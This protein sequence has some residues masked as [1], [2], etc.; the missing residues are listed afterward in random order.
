MTIINRIVTYAIMISSI[1]LI[2][3]TNN[4]SA[5][6]SQSLTP[7]AQK[8]FLGIRPVETT[9]K[10]LV[11]IQTVFPNSTAS[12][13]QIKV[14]DILLSLNEKK[15]DDFT[16]LLALLRTHKV[17]DNL[18]LVV[19]RKDQQ[20]T[21]K[22]KMIGRPREKSEIAKVDYSEVH[23]N[24]QRMRSITYTPNDIVEQNSKAPAIF[25]VQGY[26]CD[27]M[28]YGMTPNATP[29]Q[30]INQFV[31]AGFI[32]HRV[33]KLSVGESQGSL[34]CSEIDFTTEVSAF[35]A[36]L[37]KLKQHDLVNKKQVYLWGH[38][39]GVLFAPA[40]A[41]Q[42]SVAGIIGYGGVVKP[43]YQYM[44]DIYQKQS[45]KYSGMSES[46]AKN[47]VSI[48]QPFMYDW[49]KTNKPIKQIL[50]NEKAVGSNL[51]PIN[52]E[53]I[54]HRHFSFFRDVSRYDFAKIWQELQIPT[55]MIHGSLDI[56]AID[57]SWAFDI[58]DAVNKGG[59]NLGEAHIIKG[60]EHGFMHYENVAEYMEERGSGQYN[61]GQPKDRFESKIG[62]LTINWLKGLNK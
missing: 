42:E 5:F 40:M 15:I 51:I 49:L 6:A 44:L 50:S 58:A 3:L 16:S 17:G 54:F 7:L 46:T 12:A 37:K 59:N 14:N 1:F 47:N 56:Q 36:S 57:E 48:I 26:T 62:E 31:S 19:K 23:W 9:Q 60:A 30:L 18:K 24:N 27:S 53:Q 35:T 25:Y 38:S 32:V 10:Q 39:L 41:K 34:K 20:V 52:G 29:L 11:V 8:S 55:L 13:L 45:V 22:G 28:E 61:P 2:S 43:W 4:Q 21:L 33:E